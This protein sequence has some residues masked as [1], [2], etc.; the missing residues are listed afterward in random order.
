MGSVRPA[1]MPPTTASAWDADPPRSVTSTRMC[2]GSVYRRERAGRSS[3]ATILVSPL[4]L[5]EI[6]TLEAKPPRARP[7]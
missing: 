6:A 1:A 5:W 7:V 3:S 2:E 4:S